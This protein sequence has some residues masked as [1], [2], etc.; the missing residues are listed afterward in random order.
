MG[1][2]RCTRASGLD[3][4]NSV[5]ERLLPVHPKQVL[6]YLRLLKRPVG[7][8]INFVAPRLKQGLRRIVSGLDR[9]AMERRSGRAS[10]PPREPTRRALTWCLTPPR[11]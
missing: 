7:L 5:Y 4:W 3:C 6:T 2:R 1:P 8:R 10:A 11:A 9:E